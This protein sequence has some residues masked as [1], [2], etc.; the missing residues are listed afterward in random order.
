MRHL[1][2][3]YPSPESLVHLNGVLRRGSLFDFKDSPV[4]HETASK[5]SEF[6]NVYVELRH[7]VARSS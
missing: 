3:A 6:M 1:W 4:W 5:V 2:I 7:A